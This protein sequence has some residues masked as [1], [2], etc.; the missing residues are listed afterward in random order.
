M[1]DDEGCAGEG[2]G[3]V[4]GTRRKDGGGGKRDCFGE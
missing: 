2:T 1:G 4:K 3:G